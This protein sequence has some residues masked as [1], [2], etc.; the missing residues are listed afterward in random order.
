MCWCAGYRIRMCWLQTPHVLVTGSAWNPKHQRLRLDS[1]MRTKAMR[2]S[3]DLLHSRRSL[4]RGNDWLQAPHVLVTGSAWN[5]RHQRL[6]LDSRLRIKAVRQSLIR[7]HSRQSLERGMC[8][9]AGY[10]L[11]LESKAPEAPPRLPNAH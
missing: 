7:Q 1:R 3:L 5:P 4:E 6:R 2:Q 11:R 10:R 8:W 9:C